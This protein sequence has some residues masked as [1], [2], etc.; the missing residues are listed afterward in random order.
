M[1]L[2]SNIY[3]IY[4]LIKAHNMIPSVARLDALGSEQDRFICEDG[5]TTRFIHNI[6]PHLSDINQCLNSDISLLNLLKGFYSFYVDFDFG[7]N[8]ISPVNGQTMPK[9]KLW[10]KTSFIDIH[11]PIGKKCNILGTLLVITV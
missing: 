2:P 10:P 3:C 1:I 7:A 4:C 6:S 5:V 8:C 11:N 9:N